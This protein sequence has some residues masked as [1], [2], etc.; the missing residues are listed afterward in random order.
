MADATHCLQQAGQTPVADSEGEP[1]GHAAN[2]ATRADT[3]R[4]GNRQQ[5]THW[6]D[7]R[8]RDL[9]V[10]LHGERGDI[11]AGAAQILDVIAELAKTELKR[12]QYFTIEVRRW[13]GELGQSSGREL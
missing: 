6:R 9:Y 1:D 5:H 7:Q 11:K 13:L 2:R 3:K 10:P 12:L 8:K 4:I